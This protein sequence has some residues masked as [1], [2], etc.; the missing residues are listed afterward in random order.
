MIIEHS[1]TVKC[2]GK[3]HLPRMGEMKTPH[4]GDVRAALLFYTVGI[5][6]F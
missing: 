3:F 4:V 1:M 2:D 5:E 6:I